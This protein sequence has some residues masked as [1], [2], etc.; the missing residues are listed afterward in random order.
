MDSFEDHCW[1]DIVPQD[2]LEIY[3]RFRRPTFV[4]PQP[5]VLV[6]DLYDLVYQGGPLPV[7]EV[8]G[9]YPYSCGVNAW[10][11]IGPTQQVLN[12]ARG[13]QIPIFYSK[14][15]AQEE[16][17]PSP[18]RPTNS[19][20]YVPT[21]ADFAIRKEFQPTPADVVIIKSRASV[22]FG[23]P[24]TAH[25]T[26]LGVRSLI[27]VGESTSGCVRASAVDAYSHGYHVTLVEEGCFDRSDLS[28]KIS[29]FDLHHK[30][31]DV[32]RASEVVA[33]LESMIP[34]T[35]AGR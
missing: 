15:N 4:G 20:K 14:G 24:L 21:A 25:L 17:R 22:F 33:H 32:M 35:A 29:L 12:A 28:H 16:G 1:K 11:A 26:K 7:S 34:H 13:A 5:A 27:I 3:S 8:V 23:T 18:V 2:V 6:I 31:G 9:Q 10:N 30:Y 19:M